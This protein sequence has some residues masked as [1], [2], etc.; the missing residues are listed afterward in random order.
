MQAFWFNL[1]VGAKVCKLFVIVL[2]PREETVFYLFVIPHWLFFF[3][4][5]FLNVSFIC[6]SV[7]EFLFF[8]RPSLG[9]ELPQ[10]Q[11]CFFECNFWS[12]VQCVEML[13]WALPEKSKFGSWGCFAHKLTQATDFLL[14][15][16][17]GWLMG[18]ARSVESPGTFG[19]S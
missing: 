11:C 2:L 13:I 9:S 17:S 8:V 7:T 18:S 4:F 6:C 19:S 1:S 16:G 12:V 15:Y 14:K 3:F 5:F 10:I